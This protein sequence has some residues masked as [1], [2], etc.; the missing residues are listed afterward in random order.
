MLSVK[1]KAML[2]LTTLI[3]AIGVPLVYY[4]YTLHAHRNLKPEAIINAPSTGYVNAPITFSAK[5][6]SDADGFIVF[7]LWDFGDGHKFAG[8]LVNHTYFAVGNYMVKLTVYDNAGDSSTAVKRIT[9]KSIQERVKKATV[10]E[11]LSHTGD[12]MGQ[13]VIV[14]GV[15]IYGKNYSFYIVDEG[16]YWGL[17]VYVEPNATRPERIA[18][19]DVVE[20]CG[21]FTVYNSQLELKVENNHRDHVNIIGHNGT[22][23]YA[24]I[25][26][27]KWRNYNNSLISLRSDVVD[28]V[29]SYKYSL[30]GVWVYVSYNANQTGSPAIGDVFEVRGF[31]TYY[32]SSK[33]GY[34]YMEIY[35][36]NSTEDYSKYVSSNYTDANFNDILTNP[37][38]Y[39]NTAIHLHDVEVVEE[40]ASWS[41]YVGNDVGKMKVYVEKGGVIQGMIFNGAKLDIW[42]TVSNY[43]GEW[44]IKVRNATED[45][46]V[47]KNKPVYQ[48]VPVETLLQDPKSHNGSN[49]HSWGIVS[50][51]YRN[52][53]TNFTL[54]G[55]WHNES[56]IKVVGFD[57]SNISEIE[58]GYYADVCGEFTR[59]QGGWEIKIRPQSYDYV[60]ARPQTYEDVNITTLIENVAMYNNTL[61]HVPYAIVSYVYDPSWLF[62]VGNST[63]TTVDISVYVEKGGVINGTVYKCA[64]VE[65]WGMV[66]YYAP[67]QAWEIKIR[68]STLDRVEVLRKFSYLDVSIEEL[69]SNVSKYNNTD[70]HIPNATVIDVYATWLF[71]VS[72]SSQGNKNITVYVEKGAY[73][74][75]IGKGDYIE[76]YGNVTYHNSSYE[77]KIRNCTPDRINVLHANVKYVNLSYVHEVDSNGVLIHLGEQVV[78]NGTVISNVSAFSYINS[79][80][81]KLLKFYIEDSTGGVLVLGIGLNYSRL[82]LTD[83]DRVQIRGTI[84][85][86]YGEAELKIVSLDYITYL[87]RRTPVTP[88]NLSTGYFSNWHNA[89][90]VEGILMRVN[91]TVT[92]VNTQ[93]HYI[94]VDDGSGQVEIYFK[95]NFVDMS[96]ISVGDNISVV[97]IVSQYDKTSPYT[98]YYEILPRYKSDV[99]KI[100]KKGTN[101]KVEKEND[102][103]LI[104][105]VIMWR[106]NIARI[107]VDMWAH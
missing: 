47:V 55:L 71:W 34:G 10:K 14:D 73:A 99:V 17:K 83:G 81:T 104:Y 80:G 88:L 13:E 26:L 45:K 75:L 105:E 16:G 25:T 79:H 50:W 40:Y 38:K 30:G 106:R 93:Y 48:N 58:E 102:I 89:E 100:L 64:P 28:V 69:L 96:N 31:L 12:Y 35:V 103:G 59:Y 86:Y 62:Y 70:V 63:N 23:S 49:V 41:F 60:Y 43:K 52:Y 72:N 53:T 65:I 56:E 7:Y 21:R 85:Q 5:N 19:G 22:Y 15:F 20:I 66:T 29:R 87:G 61:V 42:A 4:S 76:I 46:I 51:L 3:I 77:I 24:R 6:S 57:G 11:L 95:S 90:K 33:Y 84:E 92:K 97:G 18:Y 32:H 78:V 68:N 67:K 2:I 54:F 44:E 1:I 36:R 37:E 82:N 74:P 94:Y 107:A 98:S 39:N 9:I 27:D 101:N 8:K 91:G